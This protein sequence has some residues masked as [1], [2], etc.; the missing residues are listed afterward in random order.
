MEP[1]INTTIIVTTQFVGIHQWNDAPDE[2]SFLKHPHRH[3]FHVEVELPVGHDDRELEYFMVIKIV[4]DIIEKFDNEWIK[5]KSCEHIAT[6]LC[7]KLCSHYK[8]S[9]IVKITEDNENG[10]RVEM[11]YL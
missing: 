4:D 9:C 7:N 3:I 10:S 2:V 6:E 5:T 8:R 1:K 11:N